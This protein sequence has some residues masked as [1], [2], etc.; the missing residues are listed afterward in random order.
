MYQA[1]TINAL[2]VWAPEGVHV[3]WVKDEIP[4]H[5]PEFCNAQCM[6]WHSAK[7]DRASTREAY[8]ALVKHPGLAVLVL[9]Y[10]SVNTDKGTAVALD[11]LKRRKC[12]AVGDESSYFKTPGAKRTKRLTG[13]SGRRG[14]M[15]LA[16]ARR[17][18]NGVP[19]DK[20]PLDVYS[21]FR[22]LD[23]DFWTR[24][25]IANFVAF[26]N[27][28]AMFRALPGTNIQVIQEYRNLDQLRAIIAP[29][30]S[31]VLKQDVLTELPPKSY[32]KRYFELT[33]QQRKAYN[34]LRDDFE[35]ELSTGEVMSVPVAV[36]RLGRL[37][38][39]TCG[40]LGDERIPGGNPRVEALLEEAQTFP[41]Q[42]ILWCR[43]RRACTDMAVAL[44][45]S[46]M[47]A[48]VHTGD[49]STEERAQRIAAFKA[50]DAQWFVATQQSAGIGLTLVQARMMGY[51]SNTF[52]LLDRL[53]SEDRA[54]RIGQAFPLDI[55]DV[56]CAGTVDERLLD[57]L[58][59]KRDIGAAVTGDNLR[60][61]I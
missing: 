60:E 61:W 17:I 59:F 7:A 21:Q 13:V 15:H 58:R 37:H 11:F 42:G 49:A 33:A 38:E 27:T 10:G 34:G 54:H 53:Q 31:R 56:I 43:Y 29:F 14:L 30:Q 18:A 35:A 28:F 26:S 47:T 48:V 12:L 24:H 45:G 23:P 39:I 19:V 3:A 4:A 20:W 40:Y 46:G 5:L 16:V 50:G 57:M 52:R 8:D 51:H 22:A 9:G 6:V 41:H 44:R 1:G 32:R 55:V 36:A 25:G 2:I